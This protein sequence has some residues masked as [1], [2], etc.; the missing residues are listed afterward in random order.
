MSTEAAESH[1]NMSGPGTGIAKRVEEN[2][3]KMTGY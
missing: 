2:L 1:E 3:S